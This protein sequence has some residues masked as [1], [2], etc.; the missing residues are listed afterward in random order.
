M[1]IA[2]KIKIVTQVHKISM[3]KQKLKNLLM[4]NFKIVI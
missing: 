3:I 1:K 4:K 2:R